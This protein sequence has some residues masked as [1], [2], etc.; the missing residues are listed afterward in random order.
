[1]RNKLLF[2]A[3]SLPLTAIAATSACPY[4]YAGGK[5]PDVL[6]KKLSAETRELCNTGFVVMH[7]GVARTPLW[8]AEHLTR[9]RIDNAKGMERRNAF[10]VDE[11]LPANERAELADYARSGYDRGHMAPSGDMPDE[12]TQ[13]ES[14]ALSNM[15]PQDP[16]NNRHL[17]EG[18]ES[19]VRKL[20]IERGELYVLTGPL[21]QGSD[22]KR[23]HGRV[24]V[25]SHIYKVVYDPRRKEA[26]AY[27][28]TNTNSQ[29]YQRVSVTELE[30]MAGISLLPG[31]SNSIKA[32]TMALPESRPY[33]RKGR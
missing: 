24:L 5:A 3:L 1:M 2:L 14:F 6:N 17:W 23:I 26:G 27:L 33:A 15:V 30:Q 16:Q 32:T 21:F 28:V 31:V 12:T 18:I 8:S 19:A 25:P 4:H 20:T 13:F 29:A 10:H 7:S 9:D 22:L 11:R